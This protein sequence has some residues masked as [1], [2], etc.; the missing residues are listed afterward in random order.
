[1]F[2]IAD[3]VPHSGRMLLLDS[4]SDWGD[5]WLTASVEITEQSMFTEP[6]GVSTLVAIE[7]MAQTIAALAGTRA[8]D[9]NEPVRIGLLLGTRAFN[10]NASYFPVGSKINIEVKQVF[11][12]SD[13]LAVF[14]CKAQSKDIIAECQLNVFHPQDLKAVLP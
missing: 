12:D 3:L 5:D 11:F 4:V 7:Y 6:Q 14:K 1:M 10:T 13:G 8:K 9:K 2:Q